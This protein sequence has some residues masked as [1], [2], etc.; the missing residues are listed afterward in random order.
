MAILRSKD[1]RK[2]NEKEFGDK[3]AEIRKELLKLSAQ[4]S[5]G[6]VPENP[7]R[8]RALKRTIARMLTIK[9]Q[10]GNTKKQ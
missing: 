3:M 10:G 2:L 7:G 8:I 1:V 5:A 4:K 6:S 9:K